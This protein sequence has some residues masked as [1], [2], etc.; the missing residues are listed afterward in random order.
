[1]TVNHH[2]RTERLNVVNAARALNMSIPALG[3]RIQAGD[4]TTEYH[5]GYT[6]VPI[7]EVHRFAD[8]LREEARAAEVADQE[9]R[10]QEKRE[11][12]GAFLVREMAHLQEL[13]ER[14][15]YT[16]ITED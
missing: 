15:G 7:A 5:G 9:R 12:D 14:Y 4:L 1:M 2:H 10:D 13:A 16:P 3:E 6:F 8:V 11:T